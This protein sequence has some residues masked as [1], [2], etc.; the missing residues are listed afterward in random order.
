M[1]AELLED[2]RRAL[3][4]ASK[5]VDLSEDAVEQ[6]KRPE[7]SVKVSIPVRMDS[8]ELTTF[9]GYRVR[10]NTAMGPGKGGIRYHSDVDIDHLQTL[11]FW[12]TFKCALMNLPYGG[13]K[14][15]VQV[16]PKRLSRLE[17]ERLSRAYINKVAD[18][19]GPDRDIPAPDMYTNEII[20]GWMADQ[21][22]TIKRSFVP[23]VITGKPVA[24]G[25]SALRDRA[26]A[27]GSF[28]VIDEMLRAREKRPEDTTVAIQGFGNAGAE[29][30]EQLQNGGYQVVAVSDSKGAVYSAQG[31]DI[32]T[33]R[34]FKEKNSSDGVYH[35]YQLTDCEDKNFEQISNQ[36]LLTLDVDLLAPAAL[37]NQITEENA[38]EVRAEMIF[39]VANGPVTASASE[40]LAGQG[41]EIVPGIL[42]NAGGVT[43]SY[44]EW[45]QN[46]RG[47]RWEE[48]KVRERLDKKMRRAVSEVE[49]VARE[50]D[51]SLTTAAY[52]V[53]LR[54]INATIEA[55]G[56]VDYYQS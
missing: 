46:R 4:E 2:A 47:E 42:V 36:E 27:T 7:L 21:F 22:S 14:G 44:F 11:A 39:E 30:A 50:E 5:F 8:G 45:V 28:I 1:S 10:Y 53:A 17:L 18:F 51:T 41:V 23:A 37:E 35:A 34:D 56:T 6:L 38:E 49:E 25:G 19:I 12:M 3:K 40:I 13:A 32:K 55:H 43:V 20:M 48:P 24:L 54:R 29:L 9:A 31:L 15:G 33:L 52:V 26:T 16:D